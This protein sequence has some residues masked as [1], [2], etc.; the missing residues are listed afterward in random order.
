[1]P[2]DC[3]FVNEIARN[4][5]AIICPVNVGFEMPSAAV[6]HVQPSPAGRNPKITRLVFGNAADEVVVNAVLSA[7]I[8]LVDLE[9][10]PVIPVKPV[11]CSNKNKPFTVLEYAVDIVVDKAHLGRKMFEM[12]R[13][14]LRKGG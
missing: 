1:V 8:I 3:Y 6:Q 10:V 9:F 12:D 13:F 7:L 4:T 5:L 2:V 11:V 14:Y